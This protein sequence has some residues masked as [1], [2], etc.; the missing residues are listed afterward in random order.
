MTHLAKTWLWGSPH[1]NPYFIWTGR[2]KKSEP[3]PLMP[4]RNCSTWPHASVSSRGQLLP[5][6]VASGLLV[7]KPV[8]VVFPS[9]CLC[10]FVKVN[11]F[12]R[13]YRCRQLHGEHVCN[14]QARLC[15]ALW[16]VS[17]CL[18]LTRPEPTFTFRNLLSRGY[19][20]IKNMSELKMKL[21][22]IGSFFKSSVAR[23]SSNYSVC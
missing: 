9:P 22:N 2:T 13:T 12:L 1:L 20:E 23:L 14:G 8:T 4:S 7:S 3:A 18:A 21:G 16:V 17:G 6:S 19:L 15:C 11:E 5:S 10:S